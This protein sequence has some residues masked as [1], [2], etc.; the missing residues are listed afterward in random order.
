M[1]V[2]PFK[3]VAPAE[4][5]QAFDE[6]PSGSELRLRIAGLDQFGEPV[7]FVA[8]VAIS[9]GATGEE[10]IEAA[11]ITLREDGEKILI[12]DVAFDS[13]A[14]KAGLDWDQ[15]VLQVR[16]PAD[17]PS[18]YWIYIPVLLILAGVVLMQR[19]RVAMR[20]GAAEAVP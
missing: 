1:I 19:R 11:G 7:E 10:K 16:Q 20:G 12:D 8:P 9:E 3:D 15:E 4:I 18:K 6:T 2:P 17:Q 13:A 14:Q 5:V